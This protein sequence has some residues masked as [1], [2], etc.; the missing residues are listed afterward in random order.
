[1]QVGGRTSY[2][3]KGARG[4]GVT[5]DGE[6]ITAAA[7][8]TLEHEGWLLLHG[9]QRPGRH[10]ASIDHIAVGP[11][12]IVVIDSRDWSG[13]I[14]V[15][16]GV[17]R[18]DG[19]PLERECQVAASAASAVTVWLAPRHRTAVMPLVCLS[20]QKTPARQPAAAAVYG[21]GDLPAV[22]R[23][24]PQR[25]STGEVWEIADHLRR[26]LADD[27]ARSQLTTAS[28]AAATASDGVTRSRQSLHSL[29]SPGRTLARRLRDRLGSRAR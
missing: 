5:G 13:T 17:L 16:E 22:L 2:A 14:D 12:G 4:T 27:A 8:A 26:T 7:L 28:L 9:I 1:V 24:L 18:Q 25:L 11:G 19:A 20:R 6:R 10:H 23:A 15:V 29:Q 21:V 3:V